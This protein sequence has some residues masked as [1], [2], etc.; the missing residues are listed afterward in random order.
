MV[1]LLNEKQFSKM[2]SYNVVTK[3]SVPYYKFSF[4]P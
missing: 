2:N 4:C 3:I 1:D